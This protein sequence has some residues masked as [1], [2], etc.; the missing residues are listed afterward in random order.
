MT[1]RET[2]GVKS[3]CTQPTKHFK[4]GCAVSQVKEIFYKVIEELSAGHRSRPYLKTWLLKLLLATQQ[5][6]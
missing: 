6:L 1:Q 5:I 4:A 3:S 2:L